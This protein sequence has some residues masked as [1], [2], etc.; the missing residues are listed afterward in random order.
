M[1]TTRI[2]P[3]LM[4]EGRRTRGALRA[5]IGLGLVSGWLIIAQAVLLAQ[6]ITRISF[7]HASLAGVA[8]FL[9]G[10]G[11]LFLL[12]GA[13]TYAAE[14]TAFKAAAQIKTGLRAELLARLLQ[15][16]PVGAADEASADVAAT[17]IEGIESLEPY[18]SRYMPQMALCVAVPLAILALVFPLDLYSGLI[19]LVAGPLVPVF[20]VFVGYRA[21]AINQRQWEKLLLM[22]THFLD[23]L[24]G[25]T[26]LKLFGR[27]RDEIEIVARITDDYRRTTM[28]GLR[29]AFLTSAVLEF[30]ASVAIAL[31]AVLFGARLLHARIDFYPAFLVL[32]LAPEYFVPL[33]GLSVHYHARMTAIAAAKRIF[34][35]LDAPVPEAGAGA[36]PQGALEISCEELR[37]SYN[38]APVLDGLNA[39]FPA[40]KITAIVGESG[41]G[42]TTLAR[43]LLGFIRPQAGRISVNGEDLARIAQ[44]EWWKALAWV[45][46]NPRLFTGSIADNLRLG[47]PGANDAALRDAAARAKALDFIEALPGKFDADVGEA[48][49]KLS[50]GQIQRLALAR[51]YLKNPRLLILDEATANLDMESETLVLDAIEEVAQGRTVI[52]IAHRLAMAARADQVLVLKDGRIAQAGPPH[53][54]AAQ[55][56]PYRELLRAYEGEEAVPCAI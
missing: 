55:E 56:G 3:R 50:G 40:G 20:M 31:V 16:G 34:A 43:A 21:E 44:E 30:F 46:Q 42:K 9:W 24:Q 4:K 38:D 1:S 26:T 53:I 36:V 12:R 2:D 11:G 29:V 25:L 17:M 35:L 27:A 33:R 14:I 15:R 49:G 32:L 7:H 5:S 28:A 41:A 19:L 13:L 8:P 52:V 51:A 48:G 39:R 22:S 54:L 10:L 45:P 47:A 37:F 23:M 6:V 18:F